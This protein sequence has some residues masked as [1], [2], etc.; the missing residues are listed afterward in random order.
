[1]AAEQLARMRVTAPERGIV[2]IANRH[3]WHGRTVRMGDPVNVHG[4]VA[5]GE[6]QLFK[7]APLAARGG[8]Y[9]PYDSPRDQYHRN[10]ISANVVLLTDP[11]D[12]EDRGDQRTRRGLKADHATWEQ[13]LQIR[14]RCQLDVARILDWHVEDGLARC[15][16]DLT[17]TNPETKCRGWIREFV[18]L[19]DQHLIVLDLVETA[20]PSIRRRWQLHAP[21]EPEFGDRIVT[22]SNRPPDH[23]WHEPRWKPPSHPGRLYLQIL[24]PAEYTCRLNRRGEAEAFDPRGRSRGAVPGNPYHAQDGDFVLEIDPGTDSR[25]TTFLCV[26]TATDSPDAAPPE[27][28]W[29]ARTPGTITVSVDGVDVDLSTRLPENGADEMPADQPQSEGAQP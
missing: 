19:G 3:E 8:H 10:A 17:R 1:M 26:L 29:Q 16:A 15:R 12:P 9:G 13:W 25:T 18:W 14:E 11:D 2:R 24:Q 21:T 22:V 23:R 4:G 6:F 28:S 5:A 27:A 20:R 7:L